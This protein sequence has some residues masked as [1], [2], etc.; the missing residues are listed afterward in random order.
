MTGAAGAGKRIP[1]RPRAARERF[2]R[3]HIPYAAVLTS[4]VER[5]GRTRTRDTGFRRPVLC[6]LT[7]S[8]GVRQLGGH[9]GRHDDLLCGPDD[10]TDAAVTYHKHRVGIR[11]EHDPH[12]QSDSSTD[13]KCPSARSNSLASCWD[14]EPIRSPMVLPSPMPSGRP[15]PLLSSFRAALLREHPSRLASCRM[16]LPRSSSRRPCSRFASHSSQSL[17]SLCYSLAPST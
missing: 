1:A 14:H 8:E 6:P 5:T 7:L 9:D 2:R 3:P 12:F 17:S 4:P 16:A 10:V 15:A 11:V 13:S